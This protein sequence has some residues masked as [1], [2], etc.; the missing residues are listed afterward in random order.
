MSVAVVV[1]VRDDAAGLARC[2]A[3]LAAGTLAPAELVVVDDGSRVP[4][5]VPAGVRLVRQPPRTSYAARNAG[6]AASSAPLVA[7]T[8][9]DCRP[10]PDWLER[11]VGALSDPAV[12][13]VAGR[14]EVVPARPGRWGAVELHDARTGFPQQDFV[15]RWGFGATANLVVRRSVLERVGPFRAELVSGGDAEWGERAAATGLRTVYRDDVV[16]RH[17]ARS[18]WR[19]LVRKTRRT[20]RGCEDLGVLRGDV[21]PWPRVAAERLGQP[22]RALPQLA[23][24]PAL[25]VADR[26]RV[27]AVS[28]A[29]SAVM[30]AEVARYRLGRATTRRVNTRWRLARAMT[31][32]AGSAA[33]AERP[34]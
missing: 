10:A 4:V 9:A 20:T 27:F 25:P 26:A 28:C 8:D 15:A 29:A 13:A 2:L 5:R 6:V 21:P 17:P 32:R 16:V 22:W 11:A 3:A 30:A 24:D 33:A 31:W 19:A 12:A 23:R 7:F 34:S 1:P 18:S 14:V